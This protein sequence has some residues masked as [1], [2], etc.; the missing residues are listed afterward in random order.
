MT[1]MLHTIRDCPQSKLRATL[2][3][4][5][6]QEARESVW[7]INRALDDAARSTPHEMPRRARVISLLYIDALNPT[8]EHGR[9]EVRWRRFFSALDEFANESHSLVLRRL[10]HENADLLEPHA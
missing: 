6:P 8:R 3:R 1:A 9:R 2:M 5:V 10:A 7:R 4:A